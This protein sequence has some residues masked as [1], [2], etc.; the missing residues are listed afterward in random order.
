MV[1]I[2]WSSSF[3]NISSTNTVDTLPSSQIREATSPR[4]THAIHVLSYHPSL[5]IAVFL[6]AFLFE[7]CFLACTRSLL[8]SCILVTTLIIHISSS[9]LRLHI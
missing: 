9:G 1:T 5:R 2:L 6:F 8:F 7:L 3:R 4:Y